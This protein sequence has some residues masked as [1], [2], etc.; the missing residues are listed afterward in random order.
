VQFSVSEMK[1]IRMPA[2][3]EKTLANR[4]NVIVRAQDMYMYLEQVEASFNSTGQQNSRT[5]ALSPAKQTMTDHVA[6]VSELIRVGR[7]AEA[8]A[9][10]QERASELLPPEQLSSMWSNLGLQY[11]NRHD[12][13]R[14]LAAYQKSV[15][16][17][18]DNLQSWF[19]SGLLLRPPMLP[20]GD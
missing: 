17:Y 16:F 11:Q 3:P 12:N 4:E 2:I 6:E 5:Q 20:K 10:L 8:E 1:N 9:K 14:A 19:N 15:E 7:L 18:E 13:K